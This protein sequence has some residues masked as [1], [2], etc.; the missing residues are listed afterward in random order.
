MTSSFFQNNEN[1][2]YLTYISTR[3][4]L[5]AVHFVFWTGQSHHLML[6]EPPVCQRQCSYDQHRC[7]NRNHIWQR[8]DCFPG[9]EKHIGGKNG[10][11]IHGLGREQRKNMIQQAAGIAGRKK[12]RNGGTEHTGDNGGKRRFAHGGQEHGKGHDRQHNNVV[13]QDA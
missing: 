4:H 5:Y 13:D 10:I 9:G 1:H 3:K 11:G 7:G 12:Q 6:T 8:D 2:K